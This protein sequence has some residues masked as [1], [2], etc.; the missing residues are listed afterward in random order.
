MSLEGF[1]PMTTPGSPG[2]V[3]VRLG[4][5]LATGL[6]TTNAGPADPHGGGTGSGPSPATLTSPSAVKEEE[7]SLCPSLGGDQRYTEI[8]WQ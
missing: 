5:G 3:E 4:T 8:D 2:S 7:L 6:T 1:F